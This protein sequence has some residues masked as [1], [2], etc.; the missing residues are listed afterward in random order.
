MDAHRGCG[1]VPTMGALHAGHLALIES[2]RTRIDDVVVTLFVNPA[3]FD[4][5]KDLERYPRTLDAD[6]TAAA[7][8]GATAVFAPDVETVYPRNADTWTP[9]L[10]RVATAPEL[11]DACRPGHFEGVCKVVARLFDLARPSMA[12]FGEKDWQQMRVLESMV[13]DHA[14]R[15]PGLQLV[16]GATVRDPDG[17]AMS[18]RNVLLTADQRDRARGL[19]RARAGAGDGEDA[20]Q[21]VLD[22]HKLDVEYAVIRDA[23]TLEPPTPDS[24][25][26]LR[27]LI[28]ARL[29][30]VRLIDNGIC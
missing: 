4:D 5:P 10:P 22:A 12:I 1:L 28:A 18:S 17:L 2:M 25:A 24:T 26:P 16:R 7:S 20:M 15:W 9:P 11:E 23:E 14:D 13:C 6:L 19:S 29:D 27:A 21:Q 8:A 3:Q 30:A